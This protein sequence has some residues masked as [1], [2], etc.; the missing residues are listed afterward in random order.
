MSENVLF[1]EGQDPAVIDI[2]PYWRP[3]G[4]A[5]AVVVADAICWRAADPEVLLDA[6]AGVEDF[7]QLL[8]RA[9]IYRMTT[10]VESARG[11]GNLEGYQPAVD[12]ALRLVDD[13]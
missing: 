2:S 9:L 1:A 7:P 3:A 11:A 6:V 5:S 10:T 4:F 13:R 8:V 12:L